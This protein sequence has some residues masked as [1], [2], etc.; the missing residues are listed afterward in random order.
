VERQRVRKEKKRERNTQTDYSS[1]CNQGTKTTEK[2]RHRRCKSSK[3]IPKEVRGQ[4]HYKN[5]A[6]KRIIEVQSSGAGTSPAPAALTK[7]TTRGRIITVP[8]KSR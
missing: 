3:I 5:K 8:A 6:K 2:T 7:I 1:C 4:L